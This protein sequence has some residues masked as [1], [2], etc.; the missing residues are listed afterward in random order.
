MMLAHSSM[1]GK[2]QAWYRL[3]KGD[4]RRARSCR[5]V[6]LID[7]VLSK[8]SAGIQVLKL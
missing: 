3:H 8:N 1:G 2:G 5:E 7:G 6:L 4:L